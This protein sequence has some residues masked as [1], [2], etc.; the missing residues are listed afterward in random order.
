MNSKQTVRESANGERQG[1]PPTIFTPFIFTIQ[2]MLWEP[3]Q[4]GP[5][6]KQLSEGLRVTDTATSLLP[7]DYRAPIK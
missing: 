3:A 5:G 7:G 6:Q 2:I 1:G 4:Q